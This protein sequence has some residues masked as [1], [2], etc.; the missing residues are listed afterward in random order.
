[1]YNLKVKFRLDKK[2]KKMMKRERNQLEMINSKV[3]E[4][5]RDPH[6]YKNLH[7][8]L[9]DWKRVQIGHFVLVFSIDENTKTV[10]LEDYDHHDN[11]YKNK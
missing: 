4:I 1:M 7:W 11:I 6:H 10:T 9:E 5:R 2:F 3:K 8:P